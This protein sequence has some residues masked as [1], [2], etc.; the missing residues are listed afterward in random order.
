MP[1]PPA[2]RDEEEGS[3]VDTWPWQCLRCGGTIYHD[4]ELCR[5]CNPIGPLH[6]TDRR[7]EEPEGFID[8][9]RRESAS[10][11]SIKVSV[12]A[13][14]ELVLTTF[15]LQLLAGASALSRIALPPI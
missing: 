5:D 12:I 9:I 14:V 4:V 15:W 10:A 1:K 7:H 2:P 13:G 11:L 8:W 6:D 3:D